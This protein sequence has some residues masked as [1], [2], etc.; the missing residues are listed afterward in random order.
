MLLQ[1]RFNRFPN[2]LSIVQVNVVRAVHFGINEIIRVR[3]F[4]NFDDFHGHVPIFV[5]APSVGF[6][7]E[8]GTLD[9]R[10]ELLDCVGRVAVQ[11]SGFLTQIS[12]EV[13]RGVLENNKFIITIVRR[14]FN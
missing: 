3:M 9:V 10:R 12:R 11:A 2:H 8:V 4:V 7:D 1:K 13:E 6:D 14:L 5:E